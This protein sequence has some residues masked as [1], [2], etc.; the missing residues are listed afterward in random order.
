MLRDKNYVTMHGKLLLHYAYLILESRF[1]SCWMY[2]F[3]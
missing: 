1:Q 2:S 3:P